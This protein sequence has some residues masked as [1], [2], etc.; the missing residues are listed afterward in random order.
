MGQQSESDNDGC[1]GDIK[2]PECVR[3]VHPIVHETEHM[4]AW[5]YGHEVP[6][7]YTGSNRQV[8]SIEMTEEMNELLNNGATDEQMPERYSGYFSVKDDAYYR[9]VS[10][11]I[12]ERTDNNTYLGNITI[13]QCIREVHP[14]VHETEH[15]FAW[16]YGHEV[17]DDYT[18]SN[19]QVMSIEMTEEM[20]E[21]LNNGATDEQ[22]QERYSGYFSV[23]DD[24]YYRWDSHEES[25]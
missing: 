3:N 14:I 4:F 20:N 24:A 2:M 22:M 19:R 25:G 12:P 23:K 9:W 21:L 7:D 18:G 13:P 6:D 8:M 11:T 17:P 1:Y 10:V 16:I 15:M 5:I